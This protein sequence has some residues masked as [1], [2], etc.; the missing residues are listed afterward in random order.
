MKRKR[1]EEEEEEERF[2]TAK[3]KKIGFW[4]HNPVV[5]GL[6]SATKKNPNCKNT[7]AIRGGGR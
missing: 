7:T 3:K 6:F 2:F 1:V 4:Y 5:L